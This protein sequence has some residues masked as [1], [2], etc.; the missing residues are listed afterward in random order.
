MPKELV[1][2]EHVDKS[3]NTSM[4]VIS[5]HVARGCAKGVLGLT[6]VNR[7][8]IGLSSPGDQSSVDNG[9]VSQG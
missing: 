1:G 6:M 8:Y 2:F 5:I 7:I 9:S 4:G 3:R